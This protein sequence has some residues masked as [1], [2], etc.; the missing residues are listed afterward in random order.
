MKIGIVCVVPQQYNVIV[1]SCN[2]NQE[3]WDN[4]KIFV[5]K[6]NSKEIAVASY[7][8][9]DYESLIK[10]LHEKFKVS[11]LIFLGTTLS[12]SSYLKSGDLVVINEAI[13][14]KGL[15]G[16]K[17]YQADEKL[18]DTTFAIIES[19]APDYI[20]KTVTGKAISQDDA[21]SYCSSETESS[22]ICM[23]DRCIQQTQAA[24]KY[25]LPFSIINILIQEGHL[26]EEDI[27]L[28]NMQDILTHIYWLVKGIVERS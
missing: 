1:G 13:I 18:I 3:I 19:L 10:L 16:Q 25:N 28:D 11:S 23:D 2:G 21:I 6:L 12:S 14:D 20:L 15:E 22:V 7:S 4:T 17:K 5:G 26:R 8:D 27:Y 9:Q 24:Y